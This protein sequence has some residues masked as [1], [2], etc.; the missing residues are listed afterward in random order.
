MP[1][2]PV[3]VVDRAASASSARAR[4][5]AARVRPALVRQRPVPPQRRSETLS[6][7]REHPQLRGRR[8]AAGSERSPW[9]QLVALAGLAFGPRPLRQLRSSTVGTLLAVASASTELRSECWAPS[10]WS[11]LALRVWTAGS[12]VFRYSEWSVHW[13]RWGRRAFQEAQACQ[14]IRD[15]VLAEVLRRLGLRAVV[16]L[17]QSFR[18]PQVCWI[19]VRDLLGGTPMA[20]HRARLRLDHRGHSF[21]ARGYWRKE[22]AVQAQGVRCRREHQ[23]DFP[24]AV[25]QEVRYRK[26]VEP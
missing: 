3:S 19:R 17:A 18:A 23:G 12:T 26:P 24:V 20:G 14:E 6:L 25:A 8:A 11:P 7:Q 10:V 21:P 16:A 13:E 5:W 22:L 2:V 9:V 15:Q 1:Q 4:R